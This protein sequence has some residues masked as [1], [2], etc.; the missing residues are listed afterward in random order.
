MLRCPTP[1]IECNVTKS[2]PHKPN[3]PMSYSV[4]YPI[5][6]NLI[7]PTLNQYKSNQSQPIQP[8]PV[9]CKP[10]RIPHSNPIQPNEIKSSLF[11][12]SI[13]PTLA[14]S[15]PT[16]PYSDHNQP[17]LTQV[18]LLKHTQ[19]SLIHRMICSK[20]NKRLEPML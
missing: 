2:I 20:N 5:Q 7:Q 16:N 8:N 17:S 1:F 10:N 18:R 12:N 19:P 4:T 14:K 15:K 11:K 13:Q 6:F 9:Q 3:Q